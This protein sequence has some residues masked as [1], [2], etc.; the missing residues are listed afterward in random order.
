MKNDLVTR[1]GVRAID[2]GY[3]SV[4]YTLGRKEERGS[5]IIAAG[6][7]PS[8]APILKTGAARSLQ[9]APSADGCS[10]TINGVSYFVGRG[11]VHNSKGIEPRPVSEEYCLSD[12]YLAMLRGALFY[13]A[14]DAGANYEMVIPQLVLGLPLNTYF[15]YDEQLAERV[16]GDHVFSSPL[17]AGECRVTVERAEVIVQPAGALI[18]FGVRNGRN[19]EG[20]SLVIDPG[21]GTLDWYLTSGGIPNLERSGAYPKAMLACAFSVADK[22]N[23]RW[24]DQFAIVDKIDKALRERAPSFKVQGRSY[25]LS[26]H[27][28]IV[29]Q[30]VEES[31]NQ[32]LSAVG[33][34]DDI[35]QVLLTGGGAAVFREHLLR[36]LPQLG[37]V[38]KVDP[39][40]VFSNVRGFQVYGEH[41]FGA[42]AAAA[43]PSTR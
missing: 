27:W 19:E 15:L 8:L 13:M 10:V 41:L 43:A 26:D 35:D 6:M 20:V 37:D 12:K 18:N 14:K 33:I 9:G 11:A 30:V 25:D 23:P 28:P 34:T 22:L 36:K 38:M 4:K 24:R 16:V 1:V 29:D 3:F 39:D 40:S 17:G 2:V 31:V 32:M 7:F 5:N 21:G 42:D